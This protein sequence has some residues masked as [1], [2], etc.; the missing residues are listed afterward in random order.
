MIA[1]RDVAEIVDRQCLGL[2]TLDRKSQPILPG[3]RQHPGRLNRISLGRIGPLKAPVGTNGD[4]AQVVHIGCPGIR[5]QRLQTEIEQGRR[6]GLADV[7]SVA[8]KSV[9][10]VLGAL[11]AFALFIAAWLGLLAI[12]TT[13]DLAIWSG[14]A[15]LFV[16]GYVAGRLQGD[17][18]VE[19]RGGVIGNE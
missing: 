8:A 17:T 19:P 4:H 7:P 16:F 13:V 11:P 15:L 3:G 9:G 10:I 18:Q 1:A 14:I 5:L 12:E 6:L 2:R